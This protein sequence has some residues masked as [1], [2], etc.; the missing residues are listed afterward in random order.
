MLKF[1]TG[2]DRC[3]R[4]IQNGLVNGIMN[5][6]GKR[7]QYAVLTFLLSGLFKINKSNL[8]Q[9]KNQNKIKKTKVY[10]LNIY[11]LN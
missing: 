11:D 1:D 4:I 6:D 7:R 3:I 2:Y 9:I 5:I 10:I 8:N